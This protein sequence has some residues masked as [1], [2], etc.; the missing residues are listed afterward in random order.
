MD[1][2]NFL[3]F[4]W[5]FNNQNTFKLTIEETGQFNKLVEFYSSEIDKCI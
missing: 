3:G 2:L 5:L 4:Q 1:N